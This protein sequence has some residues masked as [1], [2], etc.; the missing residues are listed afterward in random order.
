MHHKPFSECFSLLGQ[1]SWRSTR[2]HHCSHTHSCYIICQACTTSPSLRVSHSTISPASFQSDCTTA[3]TLT[4]TLFFA[5]TTGQ[6]CTTSPSLS[7]CYTSFGPANVQS[8]CTTAVTLT[9]TLFF[10]STAGHAC[11]TSPS[12]SC[13]SLFMN[14]LS[15]QEIFQTLLACEFPHC[16]GYI[17]LYVRTNICATMGYK[18]IHNQVNQVWPVASHRLVYTNRHEIW[19]G[20][21][22]KGDAPSYLQFDHLKQ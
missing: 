15:L 6:A 8:D 3:V 12:L 22:A 19:E 17:H 9:R 14:K 10:A 4:C 7:V 2:L 16:L 13:F 21:M 20:R 1:P 5:S 11:T 18:A